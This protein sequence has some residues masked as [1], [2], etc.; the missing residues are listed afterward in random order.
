VIDLAEVEEQW[1]ENHIISLDFGFGKSSAAAGLF[2]ITEPQP[3]YPAGRIFELGTLV[4]KR[5]EATEFARAVCE[6][7][8][9]SSVGGQ[10]RRIVAIYLDPSNF[11][12]IGTGPSVARQMQEVFA[13]YGDLSV[14]PA[15]ND[16][17][18]GWQMLYRLLKSGQL[19][20]TKCNRGKS[21]IFE[22]L[23]TRMHHQKL[24]GDVQKVAGDELDDVSDMVRYAM[25]TWFET[26][27]MPHDTAN[28]QKLEEY[29][30]AG[31]DD[32]SLNIYRFRMEREDRQMQE[33]P[34]FLGR[35][36]GRIIRR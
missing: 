27:S 5:M 33:Q 11:K 3:Y 28:Q 7:F 35:R 34:I 15:I 24:S 9:A 4:E 20:L 2:S 29:R 13:Q 8:V 32:H 21:L 12:H 6:C 23:S 31:M 25:L 26:S 14:V 19:V 10:R 22:A 17:I 1:W 16:R 36:H 30:A 18:A